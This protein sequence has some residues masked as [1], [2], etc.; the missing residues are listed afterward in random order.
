ML[1]GKSLSR[2]IAQSGFRLR[3]HFVTIPSFLFVE[4]HFIQFVEAYRRYDY[5]YQE[6]QSSLFRDFEFV[7]ERAYA[8]EE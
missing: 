1:V 7:Q 5:S 3:N 8:S 6:N 4:R 2:L